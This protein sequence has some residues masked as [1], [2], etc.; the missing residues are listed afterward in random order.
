MIVT[1]PFIQ[2]MKLGMTYTND[3]RIAS[4]NVTCHHEPQEWETSGGKQVAGS[5][6]H[7]QTSGM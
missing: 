6:A 2:H 7:S 1:C 5:W 3:A 4:L